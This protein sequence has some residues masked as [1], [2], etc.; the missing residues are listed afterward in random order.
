MSAIGFASS[1]VLHIYTA[2]DVDEAKIY[3]EA[4]Q[5]KYPEIKV[6]WVRLSA[7]E[8]LAR[9]RAE[10]ANPRASLWL[11]GPSET[12]IAAKL[13]GLLAPY[14]ESL[15]WQY[16]PAR[17]K[18]PDGYWVGI[19]MGFIAF[20]SNKHYLEQHGLEPPDSWYDLLRP[21]FCGKISVAFPYTSGTGYARFVTLVFLWGEEEAL[22]FEKKL[23]ECIHHYTRAGSAPVTEVGLGE[24]AVGMAFSH[25]VIA[26]G[27]AK[28]YPVALSFPKEG[29]GYEIGAMALIKGG[30]ALE[31]AKIFYD[32][33]LSA[34]AQSLFKA[35][36]RVP[37]NPHAEL[38]EG[39]IT[40]EMVKLVDYDAVWAG[41]NRDRLNELWRTV[42]G[43]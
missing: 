31:L 2:L 41:Q 6:E 29:T 32:W 24:V 11:G 8:L 1:K 37:L 3:I 38:A 28:G 9:L 5:R 4:F 14:K 34:E 13:D 16:M 26:K 17:F 40:A 20:A 10:A 25:D 43:Y 21:E 23:S 36:Y 27:I 7:G 19:Y 15:G 33:M 18:D 30:P 39:L 42:T 12:F 22:R 35:W